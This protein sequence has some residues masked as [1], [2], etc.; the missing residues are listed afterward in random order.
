MSQRFLIVL[1][2]D[3]LQSS[4][5][6]EKIPLLDAD[7]EGSV[8]YQH[9]NDLEAGSADESKQPSARDLAPSRGSPW[10]RLPSFSVSLFIGRLIHAVLSGLNYGLALLLMLVAMTYNPSLFLALVVGYALGDFVFFSRTK[11]SVYEC[12]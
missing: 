8:R 3:S 6:I 1:L 10:P 5:S 2:E 9:M 12:H 7:G 4:E 11:N